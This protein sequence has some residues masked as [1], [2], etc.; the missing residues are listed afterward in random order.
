MNFNKRLF[1]FCRRGVVGRVPA[2]PPGVTARVRSPAGQE[3]NIYLGTGCVLCVLSCF[4]SGGSTDIL[5]AADSGRSAP[6][7]LS[8]VLV[9]SLALPTGSLTHGHLDCKSLREVLSLGRVNS[10]KRKK[11]KNFRAR[12]NA[13]FI[14]FSLLWTYIHYR[15]N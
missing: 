4:I 7:F 14:H 8:S 3:I 9:H 11:E 15:K 13:I 1:G 6:V 5:L 12:K 2:F 10:R